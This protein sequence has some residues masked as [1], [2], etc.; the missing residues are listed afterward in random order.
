MPT[1]R[2]VLGS[3]A[4]AAGALLLPRLLHGQTAPAASAGPSAAAPASGPFTLPPL[5]YP[6]EALE[7]HIDA[8]TMRLHHDKHHATYVAKLNDAL[9]PIAA[10]P[11]IQGKSVEDLLKNLSAVP[12]S[13]RTAVRNHG[14]GHANHTLF[15]AS[16]RP[17]DPAAKTR[18][19]PAGGFASAVAAQFGSLAALE[20]ALGKSAGAVF[21][22][23]WGWLVAEAG[24]KLAIESTPNQDSPLSSGKRPLLGIDVWEHAYYL[25]Y[26]NRRADYLQAIWNVVDWTAVGR[27]FEAS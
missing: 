16:L 15:W 26:Q 25:K 20:E 5:P 6:P 14:G 24:G 12:E 8:E 10:T 1:R 9:A 13:A 11:A 4:I 17:A 19:L 23:G 2:E 7:P 22:S 21:G 18:S 3:S 27:R